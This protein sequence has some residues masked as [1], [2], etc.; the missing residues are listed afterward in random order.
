MLKVAPAPRSR[1]RSR[2]LSRSLSRPTTLPLSRFPAFLASRLNLFLRPR[3]CHFYRL[4]PSCARAAALILLSPRDGPRAH[5]RGHGRTPAQGRG[6]SLQPQPPRHSPGFVQDNL[7]RYVSCALQLLLKG[8][9]CLSTG[10]KI[11]WQAATQCENLISPDRARAALP[12][13]ERR[14][15]DRHTIRVVCRQPSLLT[16]SSCLGTSTALGRGRRHSALALT[17]AARACPAAVGRC[18][19]QSR[20]GKLRQSAP[21]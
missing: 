1:S 11:K 16:S 15:A 8:L 12:P 10:S 20:P 6:R 21:L 7:S 14:K 9:G 4:T 3:N 5:C 18:Q 17:W 19:V 2:L 13:P